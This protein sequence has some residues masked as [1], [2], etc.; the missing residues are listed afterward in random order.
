MKKLKPYPDWVCST[1][2]LKASK[3]MGNIPPAFE[4]STFHYGI[5]EICGEMKA[6]TEPRDFWW[7]FFS[8]YKSPR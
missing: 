6:V 8:G 7:P 3:A 1:C 2:G 4:V 5:C